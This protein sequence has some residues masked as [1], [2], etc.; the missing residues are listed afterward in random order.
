MSPRL[1][2]RKAW[3][4]AALVATGR[5]G[6]RGA[7]RRVVAF[8]FLVSCQ[9]SPQ[10]TETAVAN[11]TP[12]GPSSTASANHSPEP[13][14][15]EAAQAD[16]GTSLPSA[17]NGPP[18]APLWTGPYFRDLSLVRGK[19]IALDDA[20]CELFEIDPRT[21]QPLSAPRVTTPLTGPPSQCNDELQGDALMLRASAHESIVDPLTRRA[22]CTFWVRRSE[23]QLRWWNTDTLVFGVET[24]VGQRRPRPPT[25]VHAFAKPGCRRLWSATLPQ[26]FELDAGLASDRS[27]LYVKLE[28]SGTSDAV[29]VALRLKDGATAWRTEP[30]YLPPTVGPPGVLRV[31]H[32]SAMLLDRTSGAV[33]WQHP[34]PDYALAAVVGENAVHVVSD[35]G[36]GA[37]LLSLAAGDGHELWHTA[38]PF[39]SR[40][41][42]RVSQTLFA[43]RDRV[44]YVGFEHMAGKLLSGFDAAT[45]RPTLA[46][47][48]GKFAEVR[49]LD[50]QAGLLW[51][52][53]IPEGSVAFD[54]MI[55]LQ[56]R[57]VVVSGRLVH[58]AMSIAA[59]RSLAGI[60][61][62]S[63]DGCVRSDSRGAFV[64][65]A[66]AR[67]MLP[68]WIEEHQ[69][70][71]GQR[72]LPPPPPRM[73]VC[74]RGASARF[75]AET[76][77]QVRW[78]PELL[79][80]YCPI[81]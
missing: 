61:V 31:E 63:A 78:D 66:N 73:Y 23:A 49:L 71:A 48:L 67:G 29:L 47:W 34:L 36:G 26:D 2:C 14:R 1:V 33:R 20:R 5:M 32:T 58:H 76:R 30:G 39:A 40:S 56:P 19:A 24:Y 21:G 51:A 50:S 74:S 42:S 69:W 13:V 18:D 4:R 52:A 77:S 75:D 64:V 27:N 68:V 45:G 70:L 15:G 72:K 81:D 54:P 59:G 43:T 8:L 37:T 55:T 44:F 10:T 11:V 12:T 57:T 16:A 41:A 60:R 62:C 53:S 7:W 3:S 35:A 28:R 9:H 6:P 22:L 46:Y 79:V 38:L 25:K 65:R 80:K 17:W